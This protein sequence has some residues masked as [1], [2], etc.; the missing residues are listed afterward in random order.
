M[1]ENLVPEMLRAIRADITELKTTG[2]EI[3][4]RLGLLEMQYSSVSRRVDRIG[5]DVERIKARLELHDA[6]T[7]N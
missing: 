1:S 3:K 6:A 5:R 7:P 4:E 2:S